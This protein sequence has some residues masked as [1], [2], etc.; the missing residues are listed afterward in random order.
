MGLHRERR[1]I[2]STLLC[3]LMSV[4]SGVV[5]LE[6]TEVTCVV[7]ALMPGECAAQVKERAVI[8]ESVCAAYMAVSTIPGAGLGTFTGVDLKIDDVIGEGDVMIPLSDNNY[9][10]QALGWKMMQRD[11]WEHVDPTWNYVWGGAELG[12][13]RETAHPQA[14]IEYV[15]GK[16]YM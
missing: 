2:M 6:A 15:T 12:M 9:H 16:F 4:V 8:P 3:A 10:S 1:R 13:Q 7:D 14:T 11:D 5:R